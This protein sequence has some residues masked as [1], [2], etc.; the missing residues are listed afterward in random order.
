[1]AASLALDRAR[2][3]HD[4]RVGQPPTVTVTEAL[5]VL[6]AVA[7]PESAGA[8]PGSWAGVAGAGVAWGLS[9]IGAVGDGDTTGVTSAVGVA[10]GARA[11]PVSA[12]GST[13]AAVSSPSSLGAFV[14]AG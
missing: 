1:M 8:V 12:C 5:V 4:G 3:D 6:G 13:M 14:S 2:A 10:S 7:P 9:A 11:P